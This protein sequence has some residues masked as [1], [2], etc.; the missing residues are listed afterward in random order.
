MPHY[1]HAMR[2]L[3]PD[4]VTTFNLG[5]FNVHVASRKFNGVWTD[6]TLEQTYNKE[7]NTQLVKGITQEQAAREKYLRELPALTA[8]SEQIKAMVRVSEGTGTPRRPAKTQAL[9][10]GDAVNNISMLFVGGLIN[11]F[12]SS[13]SDLLNIAIGEKC[14]SPYLLEAKENGQE[15]L[16]RGEETLNTSATP[17]R[18]QT[19][20]EKRQNPKT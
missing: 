2:H 6:I 9:E 11:P 16:S 20:H 19:F 8:A 1:L 15:A 7:A 18:L 14:V 13:S 12:T 5:H 10:N 17:V 4:V 3:P